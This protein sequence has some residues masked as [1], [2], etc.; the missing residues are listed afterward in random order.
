M[1]TGSERDGLGQYIQSY[2]NI[3]WRGTHFKFEYGGGIIYA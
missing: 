3:T 1:D 2:R